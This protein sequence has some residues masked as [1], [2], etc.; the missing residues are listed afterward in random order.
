MIYIFLCVFF[1]HTNTRL[2]T[3]ENTVSK[4]LSISI[5]QVADLTEKIDI[6]SALFFAN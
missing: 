1:T 4:P 6:S 2:L 3:V 5:P